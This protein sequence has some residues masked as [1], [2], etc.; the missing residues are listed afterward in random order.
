MVSSDAPT[1][2]A[3]SDPELVR[4]DVEQKR[5]EARKAAA[6]ATKAEI[7]LVLPDI[8]IPEETLDAGDKASPVSELLAYSGLDPATAEIVKR[9][10]EEVPDLK[11][12]RLLLI[13]G[14]SLSG[15]TGVHRQMTAFIEL[16]QEG[17]AEAIQRLEADDPGTTIVPFNA[18][19]IH[20][21][22][23]AFAAPA[24]AIG[25]VLSAVPTILSL[26]R[27]NVTIRGREF[28]ISRAA[29]SANT[30]R[31]LRRQ[32]VEVTV[33]DFAAVSDSA[34][35]DKMQLI[36]TD[37]ARLADL[38]SR[39][40][41]ERIDTATLELARMNE[42]R[43]SLFKQRDELAKDPKRDPDPIDQELE[44][45]AGSMRALEAVRARAMHTVALAE[46]VGAATDQFVL[47]SHAIPTGG[48]VP[49]IVTAA[50]IDGF[51]Q[52]GGT[53]YFL[54]VE[55]AFGGGE[56]QYEEKVG[57]DRAK[58][59]GG[60]VLSYLLTDRDAML[61]SSGTAVVA[62][63]SRADIDSDDFTWRAHMVG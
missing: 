23:P 44:R 52:G 60:I 24:A 36:R 46:K 30:A 32:G 12:G 53:K 6:E 42:R 7:D 49:P 31:S 51:L 5:A 39:W 16:L 41:L 50:L 37:R 17:L 40:Q 10:L 8:E 11:G 14:A 3:P 15:D 47:A 57:A 13:Q 33:A 63:T 58:H 26:L 9:L 28:R 27:S 45:L 54:S 43:A 22:A 35:W 1:A 34:L 19:D 56:S 59:V 20:E 25:A 21:L 29:V 55:A 48:S 18:D 62:V 2:T 61:R 38:Q 4:I